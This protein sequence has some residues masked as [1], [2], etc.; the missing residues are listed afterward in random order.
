MAGNTVKMPDEIVRFQRHFNDLRRE[1]AKVFVGHDDVVTDLL[2]AVACGGHVLLEGV[3]GL[4]KTLLA[5]SLAE[6]LT[7]KFSRIQFTPDLM[8]ADITGAMQLVEDGHGTARLEFSPGPLL[9]NFVLADEINRT[10]PRTQS[11]LLEAMQE[12]QITA[13]RETLKLPEPFTVIATQNPIE[14]EGTYPLPEAELDRFLVK[15]DLGYPEEAE[16]R[17]ILELTTGADEAKVLPVCSG[18]DVLEMRRTCRT[19][20]AG[21]SAQ[22]HAVKLVMATQPGSK[23]ATKTTAENLLRGAGPRAAQ[24]LILLGKVHALVDGRAAVG[25]ADIDRA[26]LPVLRHRA[27]LS[28]EARMKHVGVDDVLKKIMAELQN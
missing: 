25:E 15:L 2:A 22:Q 12:R 7:L 10:T 1:L 24:A 27:A 11:A 26:A 28:F 3:P 13:G 20:F 21:E 19:V 14:Q 4:G 23:Y 8:P 18:S 16:Y 6:A 17:K 5:R 9:A